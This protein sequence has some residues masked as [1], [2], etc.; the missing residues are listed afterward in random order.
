MPYYL[1]ASFWIPEHG[2][3]LPVLA[4]WDIRVQPVAGE[5]PILPVRRY[6]PF[7]RP[8]VV[9]GYSQIPKPQG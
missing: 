8:S 9:Y 7:L 2:K 5:L 4:R 6:L 1:A 3:S